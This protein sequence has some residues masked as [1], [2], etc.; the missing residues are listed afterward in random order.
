MLLEILKRILVGIIA[1]VLF[2]ISLAFFSFQPKEASTSFFGL[3][4]LI[5]IFSGPVFIIAGVICSVIIDML[6]TKY[7]HAFI[8]YIIAGIVS[9]IAFLLFVIGNS[10]EMT[11][12]TLILFGYGIIGSLLYYHLLIIWKNRFFKRRSIEEVD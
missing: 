3:V 5:A 2:S 8:W 12:E 7:L 10:F 4:L 9:S 1:T 6:C 11:K